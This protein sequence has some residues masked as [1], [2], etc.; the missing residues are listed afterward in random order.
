MTP[1]GEAFPGRGLTSNGGLDQVAEEVVIAIERSAGGARPH[2]VAHVDP[3]E[4]FVGVLRNGN[5]KVLAVD[6]HTSAGDQFFAHATPR[7][8]SKSQYV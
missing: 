7:S 4:L 2:R 8:Q 1:A 5:V 3:P 6:R